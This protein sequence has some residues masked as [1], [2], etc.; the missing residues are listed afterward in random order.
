[1]PNNIFEKWPAWLSRWLGYR[2]PGAAPPSKTNY[3]VWIWSFIGAFGG[4]SVLQAVFTYAEY[5]V[6]RKVP[7]IVASYVSVFNEQLRIFPLFLPSV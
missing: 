6:Q 3:V 7:S 4:L 2:A 1:M 5:F